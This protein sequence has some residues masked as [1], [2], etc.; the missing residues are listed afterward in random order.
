M[1]VLSTAGVREPHQR[2]CGPR[3]PEEEELV[4][5]RSHQEARE[6]EDGGVH[7]GHSREEAI[8]AEETERGGGEGRCPRGRRVGRRRSILQGSASTAPAC[9]GQDPDGREQEGLCCSALY[10]AE[11]GFG[12]LRFRVQE[13][14]HH[15]VRDLEPQ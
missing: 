7:G 1:Y 11:P 3:Q 6:A 4:S 2:H 10:A 14:F 12:R 8:A 15:Q 9:D 13:V 5:Q